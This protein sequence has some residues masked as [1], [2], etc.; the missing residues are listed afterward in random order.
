MVSERGK[1]P[2]TKR[3]KPE[4]RVEDAISILISAE[5]LRIPRL[6]DDCLR[7]FVEHINQILRLPLD[8]SCISSKLAKK[9]AGMM[10]LEKLET[11]N[12]K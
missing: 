7:F 9:L 2:D 6:V 10:P 11:V 3:V 12:D 4:I 8:L 5:Y 1:E